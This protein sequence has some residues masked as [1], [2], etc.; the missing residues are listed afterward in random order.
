MPRRCLR[1]A[2]LGLTLLSW[3]V[4]PSLAL[5][6]DPP[7]EPVPPGTSG[8]NGVI[9]DAQ[10][11]LRLQHFPDPGGRLTKM[12]VAEARAKLN[13]DV[14]QG[15]PL[16]KVSLNRLEA[17]VRE[18]LAANQPPT[19][20]MQFLAGLTRLRY[21][22]YYPDTKDVVIAGPA[23]GWAADPA[24]HICGI[25]SGR[26]VLQLQ[27]L[28]VALRAF[29]PSEGKAPTIL[30]SIDPT[31][32]GLSRMQQFLRSIGSRATPADA[33]MI[34]NGLRTNLGMQNIRIGG[35]QPN[36]HFAQVLLECDYRMKLIGIGVERP[37]VRMASY[38]DRA[39]AASRSALERWYFI[40]DYNC[41]RVA[42]DKLGLEL[43]GDTVKLVS[44]NQLVAAD[45]SRAKTGKSNKASE[46]FTTTFTR[47]YAELAAR[48]PVF[49]EMRNLIDLAIAAAFINEQD[50]YGQSGWSAETFRDE[51]ALTVETYN[52]PLQVETVCTA[53][54]KG[55][56]LFTP[57]G[58]GVTIHPR[59]A[60]ASSNLLPDE[61]GK[62]S[63]LR[64]TVDLKDLPADR[65]WWD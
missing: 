48:L 27:D 11:V 37:P 35:I 61:D 39:S 57:V 23:E 59:Q 22:F 63:E 9:V 33:Q 29:P 21:V 49:A 20:E 18:R 47:K 26:P 45:G 34:V 38:V 55:N 16:R 62:I 65:W 42:A 30:V 17:A 19:E 51:G 7:E 25:E 3:A 36:T 10:G 14:A 58:G 50:F 31:P 41:A 43:V 53:V 4:L 52:T 54:W 46:L 13:P 6:Q 24:N 2:A 60:L 44:E 1:F 28:I 5:A 40:P 56:R 12:R 8:A 15:S 32:E 64:E